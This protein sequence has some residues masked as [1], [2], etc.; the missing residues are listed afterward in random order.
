M[1]VE[2]GSGAFCESS[3]IKYWHV[4]PIDP[5]SQRVAPAHPIPKFVEWQATH[6]WSKRIEAAVIVFS[7]EDLDTIAIDTL[8][9]RVRATDDRFAH[10]EEET[11]NDDEQDKQTTFDEMAAVRRHERSRLCVR[12]GL[13]SDQYFWRQTRAR[14]VHR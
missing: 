1:A 13:V 10:C 3:L 8:Y 9:K 6:D 2:A 12:P 14:N 11:F 5:L 4:R 7:L